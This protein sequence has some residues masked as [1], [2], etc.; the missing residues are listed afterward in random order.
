MLQK[1]IL[2]KIT[3]KATIDAASTGIADLTKGRT[4]IAW[5]KTAKLQADRKAAKGTKICLK[6]NF[7]HID[8]WSRTTTSIKEYSSKKLLYVF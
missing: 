1:R 8:Q 5:S 4:N 6:D 3:E 2:S 7:F